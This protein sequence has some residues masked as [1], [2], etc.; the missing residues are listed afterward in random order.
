MVSV[1]CVTTCS[2]VEIL[3][4]TVVERGGSPLSLAMMTRLMSGVSVAEHA[5][6]SYLAVVLVE[7]E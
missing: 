4:V 5:S 2:T 3:M 1:N 7:A 6:G